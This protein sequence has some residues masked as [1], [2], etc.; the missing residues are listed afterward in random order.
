MDGLSSEDRFVRDALYWHHN[1]TRKNSAEAFA[2]M[3]TCRPVREVVK[4]LLDKYNDDNSHLGV[5]SLS[6]SLSLTPS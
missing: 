2:A 5:C 6:L 4:A 3:A 1:G